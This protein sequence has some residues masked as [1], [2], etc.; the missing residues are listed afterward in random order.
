MATRNGNAL[1]TD[2]VGP[3]VITWSGLLNGDDGTAF[4][5]I[6]YEDKF[7]QVTGTFG[8]GGSVQLEAS[9]DGTNWFIIGVAITAA[10]V[11]NFSQRPR[12]VRPHVTAGDGTTNLTF[13]LAAHRHF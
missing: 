6:E 5:C 13:I 7:V 1:D 11:Q 4:Q 2:M 12:F 8:A 10:G 3:K 9:N